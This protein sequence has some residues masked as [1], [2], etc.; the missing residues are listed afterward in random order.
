[1]ENT[2][3]TFDWLRGFRGRLQAA[4]PDALVLGEVWD[5]TIVAS[6]YVRDGALDLTFDF[7]LAGQML[8]AVRSGDAGSLRII[9]TGAT[10]AYPSGGY[11][12]FL[13][14]HDQDRAF[15]T[16]GGEDARAK[17]AATLLLTSPGVPFLYYGEEIGL[18]GRKPDE[19]IRTPMP[20]TAEAPGYGFTTG[21]PWE[22]MA[23]DVA[24]TNVAA[25]TGDPSSLLS[26]YRSLIALRAAHPAL[27]PGGTLIAID[28]SSRAIYANLRHDPATGG[29][30]VV[31]SNLSD[32]AIDDATL[33]LAEGPLCG[34]PTAEIVLATAPTEATAPPI[35]AAGGF[36][37]WAVG[38]LPANGDL[39]VALAP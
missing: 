4:A 32:E 6:R 36:D 26:W 27:R 37:A 7:E 22:P 16:V 13:T 15:D 18:S 3:A 8:R 34:A 14:N 1:M 20:W 2:P 31:V 25:Q 12:S 38:S 10:D 33:T 17:Q 39:V 9:Q 5:A 21:D 29:A 24:T 19:R 28:A 35:N 23:D 11:A 30:V